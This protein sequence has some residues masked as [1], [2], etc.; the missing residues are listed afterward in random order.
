MFSEKQ[1]AHGRGVLRRPPPLRSSG[2]LRMTSAMRPG[3]TTLSFP[4]SLRYFA[5][6]RRDGVATEIVATALSTFPHGLVTRTQYGVA[7][8]IGGVGTDGAFPPTGWVKSRNE[9]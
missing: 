9:P 3:T 5:A 8:V 4:K 6:R 1:E 7:V 2:S